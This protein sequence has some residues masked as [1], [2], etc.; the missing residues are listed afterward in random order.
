[1]KDHFLREKLLYQLMQDNF[2]ISKF[3]RKMT[4]AFSDP[5]LKYYF[6]TLSSRRSQFAAECMDTIKY[7]GGTPS[8]QGD[9]YE[10]RKNT[11]TLVGANEAKNLKKCIRVHRQSLLRYREALACINDGSCREMLIRHKAFVENC[12]FELKSPKKLLRYQHDQESGLG[13]T[14]RE[15]QL[16]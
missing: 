10:R 15:K 13:L 1:M 14:R 5:S 11:H 9:A 6:Q 12:V 8:L 3:C 4:E 16:E 2:S 7:F